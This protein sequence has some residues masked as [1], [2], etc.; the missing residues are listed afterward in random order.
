M[1]TVKFGKAYYKLPSSCWM[2]RNGV[3]N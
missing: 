2:Q 3:Q 1:N